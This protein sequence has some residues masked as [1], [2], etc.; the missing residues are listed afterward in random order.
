MSLLTNPTRRAALG[1]LGAAFAP[2][3][4][5]STVF[6]QS[7][8]SN[9][10]TLAVIGTG[11]NGYGMLEEFLKDERVQIVAVCDVNKEG[12][13][14]WDGSVRGWGPAQRLVQEKTGKKGC[15]ALTDYRDVLRRADIDAVCISVPD[16]WH[17]RIAID[18]ARAGKQIFCQKPL[19]LTVREGRMMSDEVQKAGVVWQTGSQQRSDPSFRRACELVRNGRIGKVHTVRVGLPGGCPDFGKVASQTAAVP[20]PEGF[21]YPFW[22][23]AAPEA[24][25]CPARVGVNFRW[26]FDYSG[27]QLTDW[28]AHHIDMAQWGL[29]TDYTGPVAIRNPRAVFAQH[30][31]Y[32]TATEFYFEA[33]YENGVKLIVSD[34][35]KRGITFE[36]SEGWVWGDRGKHQASSP[37][38]CSSVLGERE[39]HLYESANHNRNFIDCILTR[40][41]TAAPIEV[42]H[43]SVTIAHLGNIAL[44]TGRSLLWNPH[45]EQILDDPGASGML[46]R[47]HRAPWTL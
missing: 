45:A 16:H 21:D 35:E 11:N 46:D 33:V 23:G 34:Q 19:S 17:A 26:N 39:L 14:Y 20:V 4:V 8:P 1:T 18:A 12:P 6:G 42:A 25:Y 29:G 43:R 24:P 5:P 36:G 13:G 40:K 10:I 2:T 28:G 32:N 44:R 30:P 3:I 9:K 22:L 38:I 31:V 41:P 47:V 15:V 7:A 37:E 27:G